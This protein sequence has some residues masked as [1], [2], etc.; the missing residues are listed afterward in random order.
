MPVTYELTRDPGLLDQY[1]RLREQCFRREIGIPG[2]DGSEDHVDRQGSI[3]VAHRDGKCIGGSR[4]GPR[5]LNSSN[6]RVMDLDLDLQPQ[7]CC[8]WE[9]LALDPEERSLQFARDFCAHLIDASRILGYQHAVL[10]SSL[11]NARFYRKC[12]SALGVEF[13]IHRPAPEFAKGAFAGLEHY[14]SVSHVGQSK[15]LALAA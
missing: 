9:R 3:L 15:P 5:P 14:L 11:R 12:H 2:F 7:G 8:T 13:R 1:Y 4:I 6:Y 10:V